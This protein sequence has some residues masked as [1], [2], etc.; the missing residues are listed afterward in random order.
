MTEVIL[1]TKGCGRPSVNARRIM[2]QNEKMAL[3]QRQIDA[4]RKALAVKNA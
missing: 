3:K 2:S 1:K 4:Y